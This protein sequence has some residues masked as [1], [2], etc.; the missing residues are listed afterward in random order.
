MAREEETPSYYHAV[1]VLPFDLAQ[2]LFTELGTAQKITFA[3]SHRPYNHSESLLP[4]K[5]V[6]QC[7][8]AL[9]KRD[10]TKRRVVFVS[11]IRAERWDPS[12]GKALIER[13]W[14]TS[15]VAI[16]IGYHHITLRRWGWAELARAVKDKRVKPKVVKT[17]ETLS[18]GFSRLQKI[19]PG[20]VVSQHVYYRIGS[21]MLDAGDPAVAAR[22]AQIRKEDAKAAAKSKTNRYN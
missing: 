7:R 5:L 17:P 15:V 10:I 9:D 21:A 11:A 20:K 18:L 4:S 2:Q 6:D 12:V 16:V 1:D 14:P 3:P 13:G 19:F 8:E 22:A